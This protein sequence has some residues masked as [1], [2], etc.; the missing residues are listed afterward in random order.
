MVF[1]R[2]LAQAANVMSTKSDKT[3]MQN[4]F[5]KCNTSGS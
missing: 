3:V 1:K 2:N 4:I 5:V